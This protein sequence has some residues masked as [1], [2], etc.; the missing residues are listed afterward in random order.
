MPAQYLWGPGTRD[1]AAAWLSIHQPEPDQWDDL[2]QVVLVR[3][4]E[5]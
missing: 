1:E 5:G 2:D 4:R 3:A